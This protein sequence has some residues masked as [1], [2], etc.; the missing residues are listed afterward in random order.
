MLVVGLKKLR[1]L[2]ALVESFH[3]YSEPN[4]TD[5]GLLDLRCRIMIKT[6]KLMLGPMFDDLNTV[7]DMDKNHLNLIAE[8]QQRQLNQALNRLI[9]HLSRE[10]GTKR[11]TVLNALLTRDVKTKLQ[12]L[13]QL[14]NEYGSIGY[15]R[16]GVKH[17]FLD[18]GVFEFTLHDRINQVAEILF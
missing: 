3:K 5:I 2:E 10:E 9:L 15:S 17:S 16:A 11:D 7:I 8:G 6:S 18:Y 1:D 4:T 12:S 14:N 13:R